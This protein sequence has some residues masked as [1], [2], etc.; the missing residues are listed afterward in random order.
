MKVL[1][2]AFQQELDPAVTEFVSSAKDDEVLASADIQGSLAHAEMLLKCGLISD[3]TFNSL[4]KGLETLKQ[5]SEKGELHLDP[6][7]EDVH[8]N[9]EEK[10]KEL[11]G[12]AANHLHTARSRNDQ[13]ALD[14]RLYTLSLMNDAILSIEL[15]MQALAE[16]A[17]QHS[18]SVMP[19]YTHLQRAQP[20]SFGHCMM[21]F[22][23]QLKRDKQR[24]IEAKA[25]CAISPLG[26]A[27]LAGTSLPIKPEIYY[28]VK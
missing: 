4:K 22:Y 23:E 20:V 21:A 26:A 9:V 14:L 17:K 11:A 13:V 28:P 6:E 25:R 2:K 24:F 10:L 1:R 19:G 12:D 5:L 16:K 8:M 3:E 27:A 18:G 7:Y 15:L